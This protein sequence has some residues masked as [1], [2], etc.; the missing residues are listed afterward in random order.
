MFISY[1]RD[2]KTITSLFLLCTV[3]IFAVVPIMRLA[4]LYR[5]E[6]PVF[7]QVGNKKI[8]PHHYKELHETALLRARHNEKKTHAEANFYAH[9]RVWDAL[10]E[11]KSLEDPL[12]NI[13]IRVLGNES[14]HLILE[15]KNLKKYLGNPQTG[16]EATDEEVI[17]KLKEIAHTHQGSERLQSQEKTIRY[18]RAREKYRTLITQAYKDTKADKA[19]HRSCAHKKVWVQLIF[20]PYTAILQEKTSPQEK[21][22]YFKAHAQDYQWEDEK[23]I[24]YIIAPLY[25]SA[26][27]WDALED[28]VKQ[29]AHRLSLEQQDPIAFAKRYSDTQEVTVHWKAEEIPEI[30]KNKLPKSEQGD[31][32]A[33]PQVV[34]IRLEKPHTHALYRLIKISRNLQ[35]Q[36][37][38]TFVR[39][40]KKIAISEDTR[41]DIHTDLVKCAAAIQKKKLKTFQEFRQEAETH[42]FAAYPKTILKQEAQRLGF[43][44]DYFPSQIARWAYK[45]K[46]IHKVSDPILV[47]DKFYFIA[48]IFAHHPKGPKPMEEVDAQIEQAVI[49]DNRKKELLTTLRPLL[50]RKSIPAQVK[51]LYPHHTFIIQ[52]KAITLATSTLHERFG[53]CPQAIGQ[54]IALS[55]GEACLAPTPHGILI[56]ICLETKRIQPKKDPKVQK[57]DLFNQLKK[58]YLYFIKEEGTLIDE[59]YRYIE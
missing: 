3:G 18:Y 26:R 25:P 37:K 54:M 53:Q 44:P 22:A 19:L 14:T 42:G 6:P 7:A 57:E 10:T 16:K 41:S 2:N 32:Q 43:P 49:R 50:A 40:E 21:E 30:I 33:S 1:I 13:G 8:D 52:K 17:E 34:T 9:L 15:D 48:T 45:E 11:E 47:G 36:K 51:K 58:A 59:R 27:D 31:L 28:K 12:K 4:E 29:I 20:V 39:I 35:L 56:A 46:K 23:N 38:Y 55:P 24:G 5:V